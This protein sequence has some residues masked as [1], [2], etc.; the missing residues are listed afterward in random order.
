MIQG[1]L[2]S[3]VMHQ[4]IDSEPIVSLGMSECYEITLPKPKCGSN[5]TP[6]NMIHIQETG[7]QSPALT[8]FFRIG[9][10]ID[11]FQHLHTPLR[12]PCWIRRIVTARHVP[13]VIH[14]HGPSPCPGGVVR[15]PGTWHRGQVGSDW[16]NQNVILLN[17]PSQQTCFA[18]TF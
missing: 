3:T 15:G 1:R 2:Q 8:K 5:F 18:V 16:I 6:K 17:R 10:A 4:D 11:N 14:G 7:Q 12:P 13:A 9:W